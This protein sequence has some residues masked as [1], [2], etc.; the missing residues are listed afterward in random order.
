[1]EDYKIRGA[2]KKNKKKFIVSIILWLVL[3]IVFVVPFSYSG[4]KAN[5]LGSFSIE[6]FMDTLSISIQNPFGTFGNI[7]S[8][9]A[10][11][12]FFGML[13]GFTII[14]AILFTIGF[15]KS[16]PKNE[17]VDIEHGSSD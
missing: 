12:S 10:F 6:T 1:M 4:F 17:Y 16:E 15:F 7:I 14:L 13:V 8:E 5:E 11:G 9:G 3:V 2:L